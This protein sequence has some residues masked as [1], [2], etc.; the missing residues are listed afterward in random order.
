MTDINSLIVDVLFESLGSQAK[1]GVKQ[2]I[3]DLEHDPKRAASSAIN[4]GSLAA[5][6]YHIYKNSKDADDKVSAIFNALPAASMKAFAVAMAGHSIA[7]L[8]SGNYSYDPKSNPLNKN[9]PMFNQQHSQHQQPQQKTYNPQQMGKI[10]WKVRSAAN[11]PVNKIDFIR[12]L[13]RQMGK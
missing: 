7:D 11:N 5:A 9:N 1:D 4:V 2:F 8:A 12:N 3:H 10:N 6:I 13:K